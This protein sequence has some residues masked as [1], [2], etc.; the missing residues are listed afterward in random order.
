MRKFLIKSASNQRVN[1]RS[2][3]RFLTPSESSSK[4]RFIISVVNLEKERAKSRQLM[5]KKLETYNYKAVL[6]EALP[7]R[8]KK[9]PKIII[10]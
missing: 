2:D 3:L 8:T 10:S 9:V 6:G 7:F 5:N 1:L 4:R